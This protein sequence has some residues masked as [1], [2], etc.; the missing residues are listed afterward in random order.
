MSEVILDITMSLDGYVA[1]VNQT[2]EAPLG[3]RGMELHEWVFPL[4]SWR[5]PHGMDGGEENEDDAMVAA[6]LAKVGA[7]VMGR[8]M[9]SGGSGPWED[10]PN[11]GGWW[12]DEP[13]FRVP[14]FVVTH[15][16]RET[17][18]FENG[19]RFVFVDAVETAVAQAR[20]AA[21]G[22]DVRVAGGADVAT[23]AFRAGLLDRIDLHIAPLLLGGGSK[24][25]A[26]VEPGTLELIETRSSP[27]VTHV[28]YR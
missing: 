4:K 21:A 17:V 5:A 6:A 7:Q 11:A 15:H 24:L 13:P 23:Q 9:F 10:D 28:S 19:T 20:E 3:E 16:P 25:F 27:R 2:L 18:E 1:G 22:R 26:G 14:V 12:G 8:R